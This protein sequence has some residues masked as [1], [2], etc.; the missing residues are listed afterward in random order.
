MK[1][2]LIYYPPGSSLTSPSG[3]KRVLT[4]RLPLHSAFTTQGKLVIAREK[5]RCQATAALCSAWGTRSWIAQSQ[6]KCPPGTVFYW[7]GVWPRSCQSQP[8]R[9]PAE[10]IPHWKVNRK[11]SSRPFSKKNNISL[12]FTFLIIPLRK[13]KLHSISYY[14]WRGYI[15]IYINN[16][17][18]FAGT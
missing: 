15:Y 1:R 4:F 6:F 12:I 3:E 2:G 10:P 14:R 8:K 13:S 9:G 17:L 18:S 7:L 5:E 16:T 11:E